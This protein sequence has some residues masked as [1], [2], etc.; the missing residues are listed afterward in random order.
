MLKEGK[1]RSRTKKEAGEKTS[2]KKPDCLDSGRGDRGRV[3]D[4]ADDFATRRN[5]SG[6]GTAGAI[7]YALGRETRQEGHVGCTRATSRNLTEGP[8]FYARGAAYD[9]AREEF[10]ARPMTEARAGLWT[11]STRIPA[12]DGGAECG[13]DRAGDSRS[14]RGVLRI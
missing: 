12:F 2:G 8:A 14:H 1:K 10:R 4:Q 11:I 13:A 6:C 9:L 5:P 7:K 3:G